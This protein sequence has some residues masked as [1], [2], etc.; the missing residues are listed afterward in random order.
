MNFLYSFMVKKGK[1]KD[2]SNNKDIKKDDWIKLL[3]KAVKGQS[4]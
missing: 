1:G 3:K 4:S 2:S